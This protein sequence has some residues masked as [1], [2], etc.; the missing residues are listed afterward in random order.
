LASEKGKIDPQQLRVSECVRLLNSTSLGEVVQPHVVYRHLNRA[1]YRIAVPGN[2]QRVDLVRYAAWLFHARFEAKPTAVNDRTNYESIK[3]TANKRSKAISESARDIASEGWVSDAVDPERKLNATQSFRYFCDTYFPATFHLPWSNDHLKVISKIEQAVLH[4]GLFA[5]AMPRGSGKTTLCE[6]ACLWAILIGAQEFVCLIGADEDHA[7][8]MLDS[9]KSEL[10]NNDLLHED[11]SEVTGPIRALEG[12]HQRA[13]GQLYQGQRIH[14]G[15]TAKEVILPCINGSKAS[16]A[17]IRVAGITGRIRGMKHKRTDGKTLRPSLVLVDDPQTDESARSPSQCA[18]REQILAGA[19]LGLSG[20]GRKIA[21]LMTLTVV[22]PDDSADR[23]LN[24]EKHPEWQGERTKMVYS[25]APQGSK[26]EKLW[27]EYAQIRAE[28]LRNDRGISEAT[29]FYQEHQQDMDDGVIVAW[30]ARYNADELSAIQ[31]A[32]NLRLQD[33]FAFFAEYQNEPL[34]LDAAEMEQLTTDQVLSRLS[35]LPRGVVPLACSR[36]VAYID[37]QKRVLF[38]LVVAFGDDFTGSVI[39]YGCYPD[40]KRSYF[41]LQDVKQTLARQ[42]PGTTLDAQL[43]SGLTSLSTEILG[44]TWVREDGIELRIERCM[45]DA[46]WGDSTA[47]VK[48]FCRTSSHAAVLLPSFGRAVTA[49]RKPMNEYNRKPGDRWGWNWYLPS[50]KAQRHVLYDTNAWKS[51]V[52][53]RLAMLVGTK[54]GITIFGDKAVQHQMLAEQLTAEYSVP[55]QGLGRTVFVWKLRP[56]RDNH[57]W[58]CLVGCAVAASERGARGIG[59][60]GN[61]PS[62]PRRRREVQ[63]S[64]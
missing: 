28:G 17:V 40:Q 57:W 11:F 51:F 52:A 46:S 38:W 39:D 4:G 21:G 64:F 43:F 59:H 44:Q 32:M 37:V 10:E 55:T 25:F 22:R 26:A 34:N 13:A 63:V 58:D 48:Q 16:G 54:G 5:M 24:R 36:V 2:M 31:H 41:T 3:E 60:D 53:S 29:E 45:V 47:T 14:V 56:N 42:H 49:D 30:E 33:E 20:P 12:I 1:G 62:T 18:Y 8:K 35:G 7:E 6:I 19:I 27:Q 15:W 9:I 61:I 50:E 23:I